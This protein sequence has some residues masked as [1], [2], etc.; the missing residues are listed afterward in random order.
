M[1]EDELAAFRK[2]WK[3]ELTSKTE[4]QPLVR[5]PSRDVPGHSGR[6]DSRN[7][8]F[9]ESRSPSQP[10][11]S[12]CTEDEGRAGA[13]GGKAAAESQDQPGYVSIAHSLLD[14]RTSPLLERLQEER[15]KRKR[16]YHQM[17]S[18]C[19]ASLQQQQQQGK[20]KKEEELLDQLIQD[21]VRGG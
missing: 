6:R 20:V 9:E 19:R 1:A 5:A 16:Q 8:Y 21:L 14:G 7:R 18:V 17:T 3:Q 4:E 2:C 10:E 12:G 13:G 11:E 15:T